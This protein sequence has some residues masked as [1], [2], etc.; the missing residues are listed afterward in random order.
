MGLYL[1]S[2]YV[3]SRVGLRRNV[4]QNNAFGPPFVPVFSFR[5]FVSFVYGVY[6]A[7]PA[8]IVMLRVHWIVER[9]EAD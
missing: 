7:G 8:I 4:G 9:V 6:R 1:T 2:V 5:A 3:S